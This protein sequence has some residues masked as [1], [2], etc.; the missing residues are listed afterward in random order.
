MTTPVLLAEVVRSGMVEGGHYGH[1]VVVDPDGAVVRSWGDP[2][3]I[4]YPRSSN[5]PVQAAAMVRAGVDLPARLLALS[6]SSHSGEV[7]HLDGVAEILALA[8]FD[9]TVLQT[10]VDYPL[11]P[12][13][14]DAWL[15]DRRAPSSMAM[16][17]S[18]KH[19]TM[20]SACAVNG[21]S[22]DSYRS[23]EHPVQ[24]AIAIELAEAAGEPIAHVGIDGCGAPVLAL[25]LAGLARSASSLVQAA[26]GEPGRLVADAM[27]GH[28]DMVGGTRREVT[29]L[30]GAIPGLLA[31]DGADGVYV[32]ALAD[33]RAFALKI[34][35]G[36]ERARTVAM[37]AVL[38]SMGFGEAVHG[39]RVLP[40]LGHGEPVGELR[41]PL[42]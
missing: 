5:K 6:G 31:K 28:P 19:S 36:S 34:L 32:G 42:T 1:A 14:R 18:G 30:M 22:V 41:C 35:D 11:D 7:I 39:W 25:S 23:P 21:W 3:A 17:C 10:P 12:V 40:V 27:R 38:E 4:I 13:E 9:D 24:R 26:P 2:A 16:N 20:L 37:A 8:D 15:A 33:G 29:A